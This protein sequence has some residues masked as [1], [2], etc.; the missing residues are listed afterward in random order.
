MNSHSHAALIIAGHGS[1]L[2]PDSSAPTHLHADAIRARGLFREVT[3]CFW[4]EEPSMGEIYEAVDSD[5]IY[6]VP[7]FISEG[8]F[9]QQ[10]LPREL[11]L[12]GPITQ[13]G[14]RTI[15]YGDPVGI[16]PNMTRLLLQRADEVATGVPRDQ[17]SLVIVGHGTNLNENSTKA[18]Q[19]QVSLIQQGG[20]GFA[21]VIDTYMEESPFVADWHKLTT[22]PH[23]VVVPFFIA[24]GLHSYQ[25]IPVLLGMTQE[26]GK[27]LSQDDVFRHNP[28][29]LHGRKVYYS[30]A[31]GTEPLMAEVILDQVH[32]FDQRHQIPPVTLAPADAIRTALARWI[33]QGQT[34]IGQVRIQ[35]HAGG[36]QLCHID[37][38][39]L[40]ERREL[41]RFTELTDARD[42]ARYDAAGNFRSLKTAPTL[43]R[44]WRLDLPDL[45]ALQLALDFFYP[46]SLGKALSYEHGGPE[47]VPLR[48][49]LVR[50]TGMYRFANQITDHQANEIIGR[51]CNTES[52]CLRRIIFPLSDTQALSGPSVLK[53]SEQAGHAT[54]V[55]DS[56]PL[57]CMEAC[58]HIVSEARKV[59]RE[60]QE[61]LA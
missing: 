48:N 1:T 46:A 3:C 47:G 8:Y 5:V 40:I 11:R 51:C 43:K 42:I 30:S 44:G 15:Y 45:A 56:I 61:T 55:K 7:N 26:P 23:V 53:L 34:A 38:A 18:I 21:E 39:A 37:D 2:N 31:I 22:A 35:P 4:K 59:A 17:T 29:E 19:D 10:V 52:C 57:I 12:D 32:D 49:L 58:T 28:I 16:H 9:C 6:I 24:D 41:T 54:S 25:D 36:Y 13:R 20:Y 27:A 50:Q 14:G 60:N 33:D